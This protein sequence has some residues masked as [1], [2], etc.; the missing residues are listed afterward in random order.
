M[1][2]PTETFLK[3]TSMSY[4]LHWKSREP[5]ATEIDSEPKIRA[6][7]VANESETIILLWKNMMETMYPEWEH[8]IEHDE[9]PA[10]E[11]RTS[12]NLKELDKK[13]PNIF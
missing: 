1:P 6:G 8:W 10:D 5:V 13:Y 11:K 2:P 3:A 9:V 12:Y 4:T 7:S